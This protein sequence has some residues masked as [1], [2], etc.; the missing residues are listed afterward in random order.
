MMFLSADVVL[1]LATEERIKL[2]SVTVREPSSS[3]QLKTNELSQ[4]AD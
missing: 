3:L 1:S 2:H 4:Y